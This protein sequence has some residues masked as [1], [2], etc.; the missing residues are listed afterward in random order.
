M[1]TLFTIPRAFTGHAAIVQDNAIGSWSRLGPD[2]EIILFGDDAGVADAAT[3]HRVRHMPHVQRNSAGTPILTDVFARAEAAATHS[4]LCFVNSD[5]ILFEDFLNAVASLSG[6]ALMVSSRFNCGID[7]R[8]TFGPNWDRDLRARALSEARMYPAGGS[9]IFVFRAGLFGEIPPFAIGRGY[10]DN[11]LMLRA[12]QRGA[13]L[14]DAT[15]AVVAVHQEHD[16]AHIRGMT[17]PPAGGRFPTQMTDEIAY[18]LRLAGGVGRLYTVYDATE[19][20]TA[21]GRLVSTLRPTLVWRRGKAWLRR[22]VAELRRR[23][24]D[25]RLRPG[26]PRQQTDSIA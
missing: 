23:V 19:V 14:I 22:R 16:Y 4:V 15:P 13:R 21:D 11:W 18:N 26:A 10:W 25:A 6:N 9:D 24:A 8:L 3:R 2:C 20:L 12:R 5:I 17:A 1:P 7:E